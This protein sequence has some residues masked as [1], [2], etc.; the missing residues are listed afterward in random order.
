M[1]SVGLGLETIAA[2]LD[3]SRRTL[4]RAFPGELANGR[5]K[6]LKASLARLDKLADEGNVAACKY[7]YSM[8]DRQE[9]TETVENDRW[10]AVAAKIE[11]DLDEQAN[12]PKNGGFRKPN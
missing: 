6:C 2:A 10:S 4:C 3:I 8:M 5:A 1:I 11:A 7:L 9:K 12:L